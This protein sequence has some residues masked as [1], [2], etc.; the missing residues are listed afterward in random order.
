MS[1]INPA[2]MHEMAEKLM[3]YLIPL[4]HPDF[5]LYVNNQRWYPCLPEHINRTTSAGTPYSVTENVDVT[6][7][8]DYCNPD[9]VSLVFE[10]TLYDAINYGDGSIVDAL[11]EILKPY[12][13]YF[14]KCT[15]YS[16]TAME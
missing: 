8:V 15:Y 12:G 10:G 16:M 7:W 13:L 9:T 2:A 1:T 11:W 14:E 4:G 3:D 5:C 6:K